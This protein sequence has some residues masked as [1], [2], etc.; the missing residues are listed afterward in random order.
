MSEHHVLFLWGSILQADSW[1]CSGLAAVTDRC[2]SVHETTGESDLSGIYWNMTPR[3]WLR[4]VDDTFVVLSKAE[5]LE[6][7]EF[8]NS[9]NMN[10]KFTQ[11]PLVDGKYA[12]LDCT[13]STDEEG[14]LATGIYSKPTHTDR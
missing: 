1:V 12:F 11:E 13:V 6:F 7:F 10:I 3:L 2:K 4:Y 14:S 5:G 8:I 9:R